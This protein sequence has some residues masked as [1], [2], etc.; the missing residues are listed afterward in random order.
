MGVKF[1]YRPKIVDVR[2]LSHLTA[3]GMM[4]IDWFESGSEDHYPW[5]VGNDC[6]DLI[7]Q[8]ISNYVRSCDDEEKSLTYAVYGVKDK[9]V[10]F[11]PAKHGG[12]NVLYYTGISDNPT[13]SREWTVNEYCELA[14]DWYGEDEENER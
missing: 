7:R 6:R 3:L 9:R 8:I 10:K 4:A 5:G 14:N 13:I 2:G 11:V 12:I 1:E